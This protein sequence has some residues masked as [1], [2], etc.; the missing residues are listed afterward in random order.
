M[1]PTAVKKESD[2]ECKRPRASLLNAE[3]RNAR[4][5]YVGNIRTT[6][7][8]AR[9]GDKFQ[10]VGSILDNLPTRC[11]NLSPDMHDNLQFS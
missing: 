6:R 9:Q 11:S 7:R 8:T 2:F 3:I 10:D 5:F 1:S 4:Q